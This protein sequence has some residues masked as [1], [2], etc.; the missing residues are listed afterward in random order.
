MNLK[1]ILKIIYRQLYP[2]TNPRWSKNSVGTL[3]EMNRVQWVEKTLKRVP[4]KSKILDAGAGELCFKPMCAHLE[5][6]SQD[7]A[8]Y[9][10]HGNGVGLQTQM[11][12]TSKVDIISDITAIPVP[13]ESFDAVMC[14]EALEHIYNP[15]AALNE[16]DRILKKRGHFILTAPFCSLT[17]FAPYHFVTGFNKYFY[18]KFFD[19][20]G[21][22]LIDIQENGNF[23]EYLAQELRRLE[24]V[25][26]TYTSDHLKWWENLTILIILGGL[27]R[28]SEKGDNSKE[29]LCHGY[30]IFAQKK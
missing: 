28:L 30:H 4:P 8:I 2:L 11:W 19:D 17:H 7:L 3:N 9:N 14:I 27:K 23:F 1:T 21:Y 6:V 16:L 24:F 25:V 22:M 26:K 20:H 15:L 12:D 13:N 5:Y 18:Q 10:G 29:L